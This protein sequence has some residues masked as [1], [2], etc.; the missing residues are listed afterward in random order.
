MIHEFA[1]IKCKGTYAFQTEMI[2]WLTDCVLL[3]QLTGVHLLT[4]LVKSCVL[5]YI[6]SCF[7]MHLFFHSYALLISVCCKPVIKKKLI[8]CT[9]NVE[10]RYVQVHC[11]YIFT[12][13]Q[14][15]VNNIFQQHYQLYCCNL[16]VSCR[17]FH[18]YCA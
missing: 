9:K 1:Y 10:N 16:F 4:N 6:I 18:V 13:L 14:I 2:V 12:I 15:I 8:L 5:Y 3:P 11:S 7:L 17:S